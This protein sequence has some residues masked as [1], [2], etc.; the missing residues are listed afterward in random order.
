MRALRVLSWE[1]RVGD[2]P[3][4]KGETYRAAQKEKPASSYTRAIIYIDTNTHQ[5]AGHGGDAVDAR[6]QPH[7]LVLSQLH[8]NTAIRATRRILREPSG[9]DSE[10]A[11]LTTGEHGESAI[12]ARQDVDAADLSSMKLGPQDI[13]KAKAGERAVRGAVWRA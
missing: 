1:R 13:R 9:R 8:N 4:E 6:W 5:A 10:I 11:A 3:S 2:E 7:A 12:R